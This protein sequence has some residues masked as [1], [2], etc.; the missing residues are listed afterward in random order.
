[1]SDWEMPVELQQ[2][3]PR[4]T[5]VMW[6]YVVRLSFL[7]LI[8]LFM[9][10]ISLICS[11]LDYAKY[12]IRQ[13]GVHSSGVARKLYTKVSHGRH[14]DTTT[15]YMDYSYTPVSY[16]RADQ[17]AVYLRTAEIPSADYSQI[18]VGDSLDVAYDQGHPDKAV[19]QHEIVLNEA[20]VYILLATAFFGTV[21][22]RRIRNH[23]QEKRLMRWGKV[24]HAKI[25]NTQFIQGRYGTYA[26]VK[27]EFTDGDGKIVEGKR[28]GI[29]SI[30]ASQWLGDQ[31]ESSLK[32]KFAAIIDN[33][34][35]IYDPQ[36]SS[37]NIIYPA[38]SVICELS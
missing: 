14:G 31:K 15:Y 16:L 17:G 24:V 13:R 29:P 38:A 19:A 3:T 12:S 8:F 4:V 7:T 26:T 36:D 22:L 11:Y 10:L 18:R 30:G 35:V 32:E 1:M 37:R 6:P 25:T 2:A 33:P 21:W 34:T 23:Y 28:T 5:R 20:L 9:L 27:Y